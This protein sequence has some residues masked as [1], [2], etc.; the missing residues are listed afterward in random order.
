MSYPNQQRPGEVRAYFHNVYERYAQ[1]V[2]VFPKA[3]LAADVDAL[4]RKTQKIAGILNNAWAIID[5]DRDYFEAQT[6][7][8][9]EQIEASGRETARGVVIAKVGINAVRFSSVAL[10]AGQ[11]TIT[12]GTFSGDDKNELF[13]D[14]ELP[15]TNGVNL[16]I[17]DG[18]LQGEPCPDALVLRDRPDGVA[19][20][21]NTLDLPQVA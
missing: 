14:L 17:I 8:A 11:F 12:H 13:R 2:D 15:M 10:E 4:P 21:F 20:Y 1:G 9:V 6:R 3:R 5:G 7:S 16:H 19:S 18:E